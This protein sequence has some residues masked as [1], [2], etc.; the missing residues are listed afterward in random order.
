M[1]EYW[2]L[3]F[4]CVCVCDSRRARTATTPGLGK[5]F[6]DQRANKATR[7]RKHV[8]TIVLYVLYQPTTLVPIALQHS[9]YKAPL[10][11]TSLQPVLVDIRKVGEAGSQRQPGI[12]TGK[13]YG[14]KATQ[15]L[16]V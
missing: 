8:C 1:K 16:E 6:G 15:R 4:V 13:L 11:S 3:L 12:A 14:E 10:A 7:C 5:A 9:P 2:F